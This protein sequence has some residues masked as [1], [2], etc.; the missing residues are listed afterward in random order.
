MIKTYSIEEAIAKE[1]GL[2][3]VPTFT[4]F[5]PFREAREWLNRENVEF[6]YTKGE[7]KSGVVVFAYGASSPQITVVEKPADIK[8]LKGATIFATL[9]KGKS[10]L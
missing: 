4:D 6:D 9:S 5:K 1:F 10:K 2:K 7:A 3:D 8:A